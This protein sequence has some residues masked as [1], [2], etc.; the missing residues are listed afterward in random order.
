MFVETGRTDQL[1]STDD[2]HFDISL[3]V[4]W[5]WQGCI[6]H[7]RMRWQHHCLV[8]LAILF[9]PA[10][11]NK[12]VAYITPNTDFH[13]RAPYGSSTATEKLV[14]PEAPTLS[15]V[16]LCSSSFYPRL[17]QSSSRN[18]LPNMS[19]MLLKV[20]AERCFWPLRRILEAL[21]R[22]RWRWQWRWRR[23]G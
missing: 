7:G 12:A 8:I 15:W 18:C 11:P 2:L 22:L 5:M 19:H 14:A 20:E 21:A 6:L 9:L 1:V 13:R 10:A 23:R 3:T 4:A 17:T 16:S